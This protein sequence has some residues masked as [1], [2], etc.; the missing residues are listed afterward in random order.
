M[1]SSLFWPG[2]R[3]NA[4]P[5]RSFML[6]SFS[7]AQ[8]GF[9][10]SF[11]IPSLVFM[12]IYRLALIYKLSFIPLKKKLWLRNGYVFLY[13]VF[14]DWCCCCWGGRVLLLMWL[15][16]VVD[17]CCCCRKRFCCWCWLILLFLTDGVVFDWYWIVGWYCNCWL[18]MF[19]LTDV[20]T[21]DVIDWCCCRLLMLLML[22]DVVVV[23]WFYCLC[24]CLWLSTDVDVVDWYY[25]C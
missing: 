4:L 9:P 15:S 20:D 14:V 24:D 12:I 18:I 11:S 23:D 13:V 17:C 5:P 22:T 25:W 21:F 8:L 16:V 2:Q 6:R 3:Y 19:L 7:F 10:L 1:M